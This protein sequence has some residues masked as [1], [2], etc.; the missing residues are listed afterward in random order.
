MRPPRL[1]ESR[2]LDAS[3]SSCERRR[4]ASRSLA[5]FSGASGDFAAVNLL[6]LTGDSSDRLEPL[7]E[8]PVDSWGSTTADASPCQ[9]LLEVP[10][11]QPKAIL[12]LRRSHRAFPWRKSS[13]RPG[14]SR[15]SR[16]STPKAA[17]RSPANV[18]QE[19]VV[20]R[21]EQLSGRLSQAETT[22]KGAFASASAQLGFSQKA[23]HQAREAQLLEASLCLA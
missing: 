1:C 4:V 9:Q 11:A 21:L 12:S 5:L 18:F 17:R 23:R 7:G 2:I 14:L 8:V 19:L 20:D 3:E 6:E 22:E 16:P 10:Q 13:K 15:A